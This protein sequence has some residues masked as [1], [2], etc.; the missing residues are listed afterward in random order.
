[1][2]ANELHAVK[3]AAAVQSITERHQ[4]KTK[5]QSRGDSQRKQKPA[6]LVDCWYLIHC[7]TSYAIQPRKVVYHDRRYCIPQSAQPDSSMQRTGSGNRPGN[8]NNSQWHAERLKSDW[9]QNEGYETGRLPFADTRNGA[10]AE[11]AAELPRYV[12]SGDTERGEAFTILYVRDA[13]SGRAFVYLPSLDETNYPQRLNEQTRTDYGKYAGKWYPFFNMAQFAGWD[14]LIG[15]AV[16]QSA[17]PKM[18]Q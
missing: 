3:P 15:K 4:A 11:P 18:I 1:V 16:A 5:A 14:E 7:R 9:R 10:V 17:A 8:D 12:L 13:A 2:R 6:V